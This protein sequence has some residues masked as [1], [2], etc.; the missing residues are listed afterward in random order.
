M[1]DGIHPLDVNSFNKQ[2]KRKRG[3]NITLSGRDAM[4]GYRTSMQNTIHRQAAGGLSA[5]VLRFNLRWQKGKQRLED[6]MPP[7]WCTPFVKE[8]I[9]ALVTQGFVVYKQ[10]ESRVVLAVPCSKDLVYTEDDGWDLQDIH[11]DDG[12]QILF[13]DEPYIITTATGETRAKHRSPASTA[14][15]STNRYNELVECFKMRN[16]YNSRP[17][18]WAPMTNEHQKGMNLRQFRDVAGASITDRFN[19]ANSQPSN[20]D[21]KTRI[22]KVS[23][24]IGDL[25]SQTQLHRERWDTRIELKRRCTNSALCTRLKS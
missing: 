12:W 8:S 1:N 4:V 6:R 25:D 17:S 24:Q 10:G 21:F 20:A 5:E 23:S 7:F 9:D 18:M 16:F 19:T 2:T 3:Q 15:D 14:E 13:I 22:A 11:K